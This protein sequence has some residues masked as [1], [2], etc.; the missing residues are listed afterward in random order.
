MVELRP[1][2]GRDEPDRAG[3]SAEG[4]AW[5][6]PLGLERGLDFAPGED[7]KCFFR[8][9][10]S[11]TYCRLQTIPPLGG[12]KQYGCVTSPRSEGIWAQRASSRP[13]GLAEATHVAAFR[14][15][16]KR[17]WNVHDGF[18]TSSPHSWRL[19]SQRARADAADLGRTSLEL[20]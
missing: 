6:Q 14:R 12:F 11:V 16:L 20:S 9:P 1:K 19:A 13:C 17:G 5:T 10:V 15:E 2:R 7:R 4:L 3:I 18:L 8:M